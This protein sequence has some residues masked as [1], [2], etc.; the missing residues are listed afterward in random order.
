ML[1]FI[2]NSSITLLP[3]AR[4]IGV[5]AE[6]TKLLLFAKRSHGPIIRLWLRDHEYKQ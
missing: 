1:R 2:L 6:Q 5:V 4:I 3:E